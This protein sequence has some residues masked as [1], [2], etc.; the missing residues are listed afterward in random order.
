MIYRLISSS[1]EREFEKKISEFDQSEYTTKLVKQL[2]DM[3]LEDNDYYI[4]P[5][6]YFSVIVEMVNLDMEVK[7]RLIQ[8]FNNVQVSDEIP[9]AEKVRR[10]LKTDGIIECEEEVCKMINEVDCMT[11]HELFSK[12]DTSFENTMH[13]V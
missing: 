4:E 2:V 12:L 6:N 13:I 7:N 11:I 1:V 10:V 3:T 5:E 8:A 9:I